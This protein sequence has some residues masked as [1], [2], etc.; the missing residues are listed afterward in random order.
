[1]LGLGQSIN[2]EE[3]ILDA[4]LS[5]GLV[6]NDEIVAQKRFGRIRIRHNFASREGSEAASNFQKAELQ[7]G[8]SNRKIPNGYESRIKIRAEWV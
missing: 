4:R 8:N 1:M 6:F 5:Q 2:K 3:I 7:V